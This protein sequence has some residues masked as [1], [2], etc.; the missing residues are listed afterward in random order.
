MRGQLFWWMSATG[1]FCHSRPRQFRGGAGSGTSEGKDSGYSHPRRGGCVAVPP[2]G[3][4]GGAHPVTVSHF[5]LSPSTSFNWRFECA[6]APFTLDQVFTGKHGYNHSNTS[7]VFD[8]LSLS[9]SGTQS[10]EW[11]TEPRGP[12]SWQ[13]RNER[14]TLAPTAHPTH[15]NPHPAPS[16]PIRAPPAT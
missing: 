7:D 9:S 14:Q 6:W 3:G 16:F 15:S 12:C 10:L 4:V 11:P 5:L 1:V 8:L 2:Q 13:P